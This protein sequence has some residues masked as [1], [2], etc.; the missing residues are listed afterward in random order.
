MKDPQISPVI[1]E[2]E[3]LFG[4]EGVRVTWTDGRV[5]EYRGGRWKMV[6]N[7]R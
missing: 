6:E 7:T 3:R 2:I 1:A 5:F 4:L